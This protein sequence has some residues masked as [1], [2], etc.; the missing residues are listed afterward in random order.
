MD[1]PGTSSAAK[2][3]E[4]ILCR[5]LAAAHLITGN[6]ER[7]EQAALK[8]VERWNPGEESEEHLLRNVIET[9]AQ[10]HASSQPHQ[11]IVPHGY[12]RDE[13]NAV[14]KLDHRRRSSF[15]ARSLVGLSSSDCARLLRLPANE[16]DEC[17]ISALRC[18]AVLQ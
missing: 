14:L 5:A 9:A 13:L 16:I 7:A 8:A 18:L 17:N 2:D 3:V 4:Q 11:A 15:V 10:A 12:L 6:L 1:R